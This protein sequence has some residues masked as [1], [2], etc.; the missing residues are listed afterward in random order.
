MTDL[1]IWDHCYLNGDVSK[2]IEV[3]SRNIHEIEYGNKSNNSINT[4]HSEQLS[5]LS[6]GKLELFK[7]I[8]D[9]KNSKKPFPHCY[10]KMVHR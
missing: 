10:M 5:S 1:S 6:T 3:I 7:I 8:N 2:H 4:V 9:R